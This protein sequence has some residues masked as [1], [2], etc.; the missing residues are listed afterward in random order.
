ML[1]SF[2]FLSLA[3]LLA[4]PA[5]AVVP[6]RHSPRPITLPAGTPISVRLDQPLSTEYDRPGAQF[7]AT[8]S[9]PL[10]REGEVVLPRGTRFYGSVV[11][12]QKSGQLKGRAVMA[13]RLDSIDVR[14]RI[15]PVVTTDEEFVGKSHK[16]HNMRWIGGGGGGGA[17]VGAIAG[18]PV[19][20]LVGAGV[21]AGGGTAGAAITSK[22]NL[23]LAPETPLM[24]TLR[25]P[26]TL[27]AAR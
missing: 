24:F 5:V 27:R 8:L 7:A 20:A 12:S 18:G 2:G 9:A 10:V 21:G 6:A 23:S 22:R 17:V 16:G 15:H 4:L 14:G 1:R 3:V 19:G 25:Q 13:L 11:A 26:V